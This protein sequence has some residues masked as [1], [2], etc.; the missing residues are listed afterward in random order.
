MT[1]KLRSSRL[2]DHTCRSIEDRMAGRSMNQN[3]ITQRRVRDG[4]TTGAPKKANIDG[5]EDARHSKIKERGPK[6]QD[7][8]KDD[9]LSI[10]L[11]RSISLN[12]Y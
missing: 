10:S 1:T 2:R 12:R 4:F 7:D 3:R 8:R 6:A 9:L 11:D 5:D